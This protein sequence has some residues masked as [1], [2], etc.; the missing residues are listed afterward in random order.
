MKSRIPVGGV[1]CVRC[2]LM[3]AALACLVVPVRSVAEAGKE[4]KQRPN[5]VVIVADDLGYADLGC[6]GSKDVRTPQIDA[7]AAGGVRFTNGYVS[8]P[9]CSPTRA[10]L[11]TG[12][13][14]QRFGHEFNPGPPAQASPQ[15]GLPLEEKTIAERFKAAGYVTGCVGKWHL[16]LRDAYLPTSRGFD[17]FFGFPHGSHSYIDARA[18]SVNPILRGT[19]AVE[20][21]EYLTDAFTREAVAFIDHHRDEP[22]F[23][24]LAYN[25]I[26]TPMQAPAKYL[27]RF[28][29]VADSKRRTMLAMLSAMDDGVGEVM[30]KLRQARLDERTLVVFVSD[31]G[32]PTARNGSRNDPLRGFKGQVLEGGIRV[33]FMMAWEGR[34]PAGKVYERPV[35]SLDIL[36]TALASAGITPAADWKLD[37]VN[38]LP[39]LTG[40]KPEAPH[41]TLFWRFGP[42]SA[43]RQGRWKLIEHQGDAP[44]LYDLAADV[45]EQNDLAIKMPDKVKALQQ[46]YQSWNVQLAAPR[47]PGAGQGAGRAKL[48]RA[49]KGD[50]APW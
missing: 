14:Q 27:D 33:P 19:K 28:P 47:W 40:E 41:E 18:D 10:G 21:E 29:N 17:K 12:R 4:V 31:N 23:L 22:F 46:V 7:L 13:Y 15:F 5:V 48:Q 49:A 32:G 20:K 26:H 42:Q 9:V 45:G 2:A 34:L 37:G 16:G 3:A 50:K 39:H 35:I 6:Q 38:L 1:L 11:M 24:Y 36:P 8:C 44:Q 30:A 43:I 25:A